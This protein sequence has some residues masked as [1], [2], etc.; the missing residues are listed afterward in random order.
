MCLISEGCSEKMK[1]T[2]TAWTGGNDL[3]I[4]GQYVWGNSNTSMV[5]TNWNTNEPSLLIPQEAPSRDC[6]DLLRNGK[7]N[8]RPCWYLNPFICEKN[9]SN[10]YVT[11]YI[12]LHKYLDEF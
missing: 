11:N 10:Y 1:L 7:W 6:V 12:Q 2:C 8:D 5:L 9:I 3:Y 4:E